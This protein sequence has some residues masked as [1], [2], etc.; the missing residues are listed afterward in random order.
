[1][2]KNFKSIILSSVM[3]VLFFAY[4]VSATPITTNARVVS[5]A[6]VSAVDNL[7]F[8]LFSVGVVGCD[9][10]FNAGD[11]ISADPDVTLLGSE[12]GGEVTVGGTAIGDN[13]QVNLT[14]TD[15]TGPGTMTI[16]PDCQ[17]QGAGAPTAN[18]CT[19]VATGAT[20]TVQVGGVLTVGA[21]QPVG[22]YSGSIE[23]TAGFF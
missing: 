18:L 16:V 17:L 4:N 9:I 14:A 11:I 2:F 8:G 21:S 6:T 13:V 22:L 20:D 10:T 12:L 3:L 23:V 7:N 5:S 19:Y 15:L 1:M